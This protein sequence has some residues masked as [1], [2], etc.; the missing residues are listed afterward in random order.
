[1]PKQINVT[2]ATFHGFQL[3]AI[4]DELLASDEVAR[5]GRSARVLVK[6]DTLTV[7]LTAV[8][9]GGTL[10]E[11][12]APS[13]LIVIPVRGE[14]DFSHEGETLSATGSRAL[15]LGP[16][17]RHSVAARTDCAFLLIFGMSPPHPADA[18]LRESE[19]E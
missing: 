9:E 7:V 12:S 16:G 6:N 11:H 15:T 4:V 17:L 3:D 19:A 1:V 14:A 10:K 8:R 2:P 13:T 5:E 18:V